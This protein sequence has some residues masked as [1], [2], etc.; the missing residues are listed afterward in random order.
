MPPG[1]WSLVLVV[2]HLAFVAVLALLNALV[3]EVRIQAVPVLPSSERPVARALPVLRPAV[4][5]IGPAGLARFERHIVEGARMYGV[6]P[7]LIRAVI[8]AESGGN[9]Q[10]VSKRGARGLAQILPST[11][12]ELGAR[13]SEDL[14]DP[15]TNILLG[16]KY[17]SQLLAEF[18]GD[19]GRALAAYNGGRE[20]LY[21]ERL[22]PAETRAYVPRVLRLWA[23]LRR[24]RPPA[25]S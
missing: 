11:G 19:V 6:D 18:N 10:A 23:R 21:N 17:L 9:P 15:R 16:T 5:F 2:T 1:T 24:S 25:L 22:L 12:R 13:R 4:Q 8:L 20:V 14:F 7:N 3:G